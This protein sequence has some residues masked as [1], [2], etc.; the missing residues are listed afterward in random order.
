MANLRIHP[1][2]GVARVGNSDQ[3]FVGPEQPGIPA[4]WDSGNKIFKPFKDAQGKVLR[5]AVRF[6][7]FE[8]DD[9]GNPLKEIT[10]A[11]GVK[12]EWRVHVANRKASFFTFH[13]LSGAETNPPYT[14]RQGRP[15][16]S[17]ERKGRGR[18]QPDLKNKRNP[19]VVNRGDLE[20]DPG[21]I[22]ISS[23]GDVD[24]V[25][26]KTP[27]PIKFLGHLKMEN[28]GRL[29]FFGGLG[30]TA[31]NQTPAPAIEDYANNDTWFD[32]VCDGVVQAVVT[33]PTGE[34]PA[35][36]SAW[37][38]VAP[39][40]FAP[41][42]GNVVSLYDL[43]WDLSV[44]LR[45]PCQAG[46][47]PLLQDLIA[48]QLAWQE[49]TSDFA[50]SYQPSF[51]D[52]IYPILS[53][54]LAAYDVQETI[55]RDAHG[56]LADWGRLSQAGDDTERM[57]R[58]VFN[59]LRNPNS[60][61]I[62]R[63]NMPRGLG[64]EYT[65]LDDFE[66]DGTGSPTARSFLSVTRVQYALLKAWAGGKCKDDWSF[67]GQV[68]Y[69]PIPTPGPI[70]PHGL[71]KAVLE[72]C[73]GGPFYP[74]IEVSWLIR[75]PELYAAAFRFDEPG[76]SIGP[77]PF[78]PG[79]FSQQMAL[80]WT[81]D[82]YDCH[83]EEHTPDESQES[84]VYMWWTAQRP[85]DVRSEAGGEYRRWVERFDAFK[86]DGT[87]ADDLANLARFEQMRTRW[88]ELSFIV[89]DDDEFLEQK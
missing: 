24:L 56:T 45:L 46:N 7:I 12:I 74:G 49:A 73:V 22:S 81:A 39:P 2:I 78:Q 38:T 5:Q 41:G 70:T 14:S 19:S 68:K 86:E 83:K 66:E 43:I 60:D 72:N 79:F 40:D 67:G 36:Q 31:S 61:Q 25:D 34:T 64:D 77:L 30:Q 26:S 33:L 21:V 13:G 27:A 89:L 57:R 35:V 23:P 87:D 1:A 76:F 55:R 62:D 82:F 58:F 4:N 6:R 3:F 54:A 9:L 44:R 10:L 52:H 32:D 50:S 37:V 84:V 16:D 8:F 17:I 11:D 20:I 80:P 69:A 42:I 47:D 88:F 15:A 48:Q 18:G 28:Q 71:D 75:Q 63:L 29:L 53:R 59:R 65:A 51:T 85:D